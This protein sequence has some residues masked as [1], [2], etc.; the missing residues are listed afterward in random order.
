M[1]RGLEGLVQDVP[2]I[3]AG[4]MTSCPSELSAWIG[5]SISQANYEIGPDVWKILEQ[6]APET[7][8]ESPDSDKKRLADLSLLSEILLRRAGVRNIFSRGFAPM[9]MRRHSPTEEPL[10]IIRRSLLVLAWQQL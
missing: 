7:L 6:I 1:P 5:P 8:K 9:I 3:L 4:E 10:K 2:G